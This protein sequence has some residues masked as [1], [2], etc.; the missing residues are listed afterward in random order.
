MRAWKCCSPC[1][2]VRNISPT[3]DPV[4][5]SNWIKCGFHLG[6][7]A[8]RNVCHWQH[9][10]SGEQFSKLLILELKRF[11]SKKIKFSALIALLRPLFIFSIFFYKFEN[12]K[13]FS[14]FW[15]LAPTKRKKKSNV[16][17]AMPAQ[18]NNIKC[19]IKVIKLFLIL[20]L[21]DIFHL[22]EVEY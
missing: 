16:E 18:E 4:L 13:Y 15:F 22:W 2:G 5:L 1:C 3:N 21:S 11:G 20:L 12:L 8:D 19:L 10:K 7:E 6:G 17:S 9:I 14:D